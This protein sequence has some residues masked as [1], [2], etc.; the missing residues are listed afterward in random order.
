MPHKKFQH[1]IKWL[2]IFIRA[3]TNIQKKKGKIKQK[4][5]TERPTC[6]G[7]QLVAPAQVHLD[8]C[9]L[10]QAS[11]HAAACRPCRGRRRHCDTLATQLLPCRLLRVLETPRSLPVPFPLSTD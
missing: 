2:D 3:K 9:R 8:A 7:A 11:G 4:F 1:F 10:P 5:K 6:E